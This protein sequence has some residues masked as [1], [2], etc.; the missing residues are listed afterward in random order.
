[1]R[2]GPIKLSAGNIL[3]WLGLGVAELKNFIRERSGGLERRELRVLEYVR[4]NVAPNS[5]EKVLAAMDDFARND[6]FLMNV[7]DEKGPILDSAVVDSGA[8]RALELGA[9]CGYSAVRIARLLDK[10]GSTLTSIELSKTRS[11]VVRGMVAHAGLADRVTVINA[12]TGEAIPTLDAPFDVVFL[13]HVKEMYLADLLALE[14]HGLLNPGCIVVADNVGMFAGI[15][16]YLDHVR[17]SGKYTSVHH[18]ATIEYREDIYDM[19]E[20]STW[21]GP[22]AE[23]TN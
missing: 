16:G 15:E 20:V 22:T 3:P 14:E 6:A 4:T 17:T 13:D 12:P 2:I 8:G 18:D 7:G 5:P 19:V 23:H 21:I 11:E 10:P 1:M 9:F